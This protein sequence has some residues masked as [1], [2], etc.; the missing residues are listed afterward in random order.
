MTTAM[1]LE[2]LTPNQR[3]RNQLVATGIAPPA[4]GAMPGCGPEGQPPCTVLTRSG[5]SFAAF[6]VP[7]PVT[8]S[9][10]V[11]AE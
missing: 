4:G 6:G 8:G 1:L 10:P 7:S 2:T 5:R 11:P 3:A 9:H